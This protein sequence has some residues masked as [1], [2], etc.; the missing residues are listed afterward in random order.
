V[1]RRGLRLQL[2]LLGNCPCALKGQVRDGKH[3][4]GTAT[5]RA[6]G[7]VTLTIRL[8]APERRKLRHRRRATLTVRLTVTD[9][10]GR[11]RLRTKTVRLTR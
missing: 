8:R 10:A 9:T 3:V 7:A 2:I 1:A 11:S 4:V 5:R 6:G